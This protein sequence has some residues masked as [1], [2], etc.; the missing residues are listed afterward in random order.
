MR[1]INGAVAVGVA[2]AVQFI[3][4]IVLM[5]ASPAHAD[6]SGYRR[7]VGNIAELPLQAPEP[8]SLP[9]PRLI[10]QDLNSG[11]SPGAEVQRVTQKGFDP[12]TADAIV[13]CV[14]LESP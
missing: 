1:F 11:V 13:Q 14:V 7:C 9:L 8:R 10:E 3:A 4:P 12:Q 2:V 6:I 5:G